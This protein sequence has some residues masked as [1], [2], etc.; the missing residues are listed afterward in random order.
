MKPMARQTATMLTSA[1]E[2]NRG[3]KEYLIRLHETTPPRAYE[4]GDG[5][6]R[7]SFYSEFLEHYPKRISWRKKLFR[8]QSG[9]LAFTKILLIPPFAAMG[10]ERRCI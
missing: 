1:A 6:A 10:V 7:G 5:H 2:P 9:A 3:E 4:V 8:G